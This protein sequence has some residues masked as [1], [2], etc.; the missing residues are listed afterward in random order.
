M[1]AS[2]YDELLFDYIYYF[3]YLFEF[4][5]KI[6][7]LNTS[8]YVAYICDMHYWPC[9]GRPLNVN[10]CPHSGHVVLS[11]ELHQHFTTCSQGLPPASPSMYDHLSEA[12]LWEASCW[13][14]LQGF[15]PTIIV[16][17]SQ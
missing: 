12:L 2:D 9:R 16:S 17:C 11:T 10:R 1:T 6:F 8:K 15:F 7:V 4:S 13:D 14:S 3:T 5:T